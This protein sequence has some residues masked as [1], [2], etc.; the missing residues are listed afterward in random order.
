MRALK[1]MRGGKVAKSYL[2]PLAVRVECI[3]MGQEGRGW[4]R[5]L[6]FAELTKSRKGVEE[7]RKET[8]PYWKES[9]PFWCLP[10]WQLIKMEGASDIYNLIWTKTE[11]GNCS[12]RG[13]Y[14]VTSVL[15]EWLLRTAVPMAQ[16]TKFEVNRALADIANGVSHCTIASQRWGVPRSTLWNRL[17]GQQQRSAAF[18]DLQRLSYDQEAKLASRVQIQADLDLAPIY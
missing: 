6:V 17:K 18:E 15:A 3:R 5:F 1:V 2:D 11:K 4:K 10:Y 9:D 13:R 16:Y 8:G 12:R 7:K 14:S